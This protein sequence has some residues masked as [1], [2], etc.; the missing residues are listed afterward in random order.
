MQGLQ[1]T[2]NDLM[3][4]Q[5]GPGRLG[6]PKLICHPDELSV[7][8][9]EDFGRAIC[10]IRSRGLPILPDF[11]SELHSSWKAP[12][13]SALARTQLGNPLDRAKDFG[14]PFERDNIRPQ[15]SCMLFCLSTSASSPGQ[16]EDVGSLLEGLL[17][18]CLKG[19]A[20][21]DAGPGGAAEGVSMVPPN[22]AG[23]AISSSELTLSSKP[24]EIQATRLAP[25]WESSRD[26]VKAVITALAAKAHLQ[27]GFMPHAVERLTRW[28]Q[29]RD[30]DPIS[31]ETE[32]ISLFLQSLLESGLTESTLKERVSELHALS[33]HPAC[34]RLGDEGSSN[35]LL[36][37]PH[38]CPVRR[39]LPRSN[40]SRPLV[41]ESFYPPPHTSAEA[42]RMHLLC[43]VRA[44]RRYINCTKQIR[45]TN[46]LYVCFGDLVRGQPVSRQR[47]AKW[48]V[49]LTELAYHSMGMPPPEGV[50]A[51]STRGMAASWELIR[52]ASA[53]GW[54]S[55]LTF[56][57]FYS[58]DVASTVTA[59]VLQMAKQE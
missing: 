56:A 29:S 51:H 22:E 10:S 15:G 2:L 12:S 32:S 44:L 35:S 19:A 50:G 53:A 54:T 7:A 20:V 48:M 41:L 13:S 6:E 47:L 16:S 43:P 59:F 21:M 34:Q 46:Q 25:R 38:S 24:R 52:G 1:K 37:I 58:L 39:V 11:V 33:V 55:S 14:S 9:S 31:S 8:A 49:R 40:V 27:G 18:A 4:A 42:A 45:R 26:L 3:L 28:Y 36:P 30:T 57:K 23:H 17:E 5:Q